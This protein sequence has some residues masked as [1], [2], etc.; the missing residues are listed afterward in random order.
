[1][2]INLRPLANGQVRYEAR[3]YKRSKGK[4]RT[5]RFDTREEAEW[6]IRA[7]KE[8]DDRD[9]HQKQNLSDT[10]LRALQNRFLLGR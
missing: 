4:S 9:S 8:I 3:L 6:Q 10:E 2:A 5:R 7:W 1:M